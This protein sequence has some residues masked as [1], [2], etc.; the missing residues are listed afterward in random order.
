MIGATRIAARRLAASALAFATLMAAAPLQAN[1]VLGTPITGDTRLI[2]YVYNP[3]NTYLVLSK[4]KAVTHVQFAANETIRTVA[5]GDTANWELNATKDRRNLFI[6]PKFEGD[7]T[8]L[9]VL[10]DLRAY[11]FVLRSTGEGKKWHQRVS[12]I[13]GSD[14]LLSLPEADPPVSEPA[15]AAAEPAPVRVQSTEPSAASSSA[16][17]QQA[18]SGLRPDKLR[19]AYQITG[20]AP[21]RPSIVFDDGRFTYFKLPSNIQELPALFAVTESTEYSLVNFEVQGEYIV[22]QRLM[23][24]AVLKLGRAEVRVTL[25]QQAPK[26]SFLGIPLS[27]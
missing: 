22:A 14:M 15:R 23:P 5:A 9:T 27:D 21:F 18:P 25:Q 6:K 12:W 20:D 11:Q 17:D 10:T 19:F 13:Y 26:R 3:D 8:T 4:P 2:Q 1:V 16:G 24:H 7:E